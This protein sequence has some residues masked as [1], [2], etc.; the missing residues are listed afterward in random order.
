MTTRLLR[1]LLPLCFFAVLL[2]RVH[3]QTSV[4]GTQ[5]LAFAR[6][7]SAGM[8]GQINGVA[9][10]A[11]G[12]VYLLLDQKDG[13]RLLKTDN[14][15]STILAQAQL[16]AVGDIGLALAVNSAGNVFI[17]GT[18]TSSTLTGT[19]G[20]A[21]PQR[22]DT[23]TNSFVAGLDS[24]LN[25][26]FVTFTGG[27]RIAASALAV[28]ND[29]VFVTGLLY[30][31][32]LPV[33][34]NGILQAAAS[35]SSGNGFVER[36]SADGT[37]LVYAT[38][39]TGASGDTSPTAIAADPTDAAYIAGS[40]TASGYPTVAALVP[41]ILSNPSGF[42]TKLTPA[43]DGITF[44]T[45][46]PGAGITSLALDTNGTTLLASGT[47]AQGQF[48]VDTV[49]S[50]LLSI[51]TQVLLKL[52]LDGSSVQ[53][54]IALAPGT[55]SHVASTSRSVAWVDGLLT[56]PLLPGTPLAGLGTG[57]ALRIPSSNSIDQSVRLGGL[58]DANPSFASLP[59]R[60]TSV[61]IDPTG[62]PFFAGAVLPTASS[63]LL[64]TETYELPLTSATSALPSSLRTTEQTASTCT[65]SL[66]AGSAAYLTRINPAG[67]SAALA[68]SV[69]DA[70]FVTLRN[71]SSTPA[72]SLTL[73]SS[74]GQPL[75]TCTQ[76]L[77]AGADC[78]AILPGTAAST[79]TLSAG[80]AATQQFTVPASAAQSSTLVFS[81]RELDFGIVPA[82]TPA[83][84]TITVT[85]LGSVAQTFASTLDSAGTSPYSE[86]SSDCTSSGAVTRKTLP[87]GATC[88]VVLALT[89]STS[90]TD[91]QS[92]S[93]L[94]GTRDIALTGYTQLAA[95]TLSAS[96]LDFGTQFANGLRLPR[97][98]YLYN[99]TS[100]AFAHTIATLPSG[101]PFTVSDTCPTSIASAQICRI[102]V[103]Y[104]SSTVP[105]NDTAILNLDA[106]ASVL[107]TGKTLAA[108]TITGTTV[109]PNLGVTPTSI[110]FANAVVVTGVSPTT[111][112]VS[113]TNT[114]ASPFALTLALSGDFTD[115]TSCGATLAGGQTCAVA[116]TFAPSEPGTRTGVLAVT[117]GA[118]TSPAY[119][120][121]T[122]TGTAILPANDGTLS[123]GGVPVSQPRV[124]FYKVAQPFTSLAAV[125]SGPYTVALVEDIGYGYGHPSAASYSAATKGTCS[126][127]FLAIQFLPTA[128]GP[129][130]GTLTLSSAAGGS[131]Y[132]LTLTGLGLP[133]TG[134]LINPLAQDFGT[135]PV[136]SQSGANLFT[137]TNLTAAGIAVTLTVPATTGD[138]TPSTNA[139]GGQ[140]CTG[141]LAYTASC[142]VAVQFT[143]T[144]TGA[145]TGTLAV[146]S[147]GGNATATLTGFSS[148]DPGISIRPLALTFSDVPG[149]TEIRQTVTLT[150]TGTS[151]LQVLTPTIGTS[152]LRRIL[153]LRLARPPPPPAPSPSPTPPAQPT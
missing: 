54:S 25:L 122:G 137:V 83:T 21:I 44:S 15:A 102:R 153:H 42:L 143:P 20:A 86:S 130:P 138:F 81:P 53:S 52:P 67:S 115:V 35:G 56:L 136:N 50:P 119:V 16:G 94:I 64:S 116:L 1:A 133:T 17:T 149:P 139:T 100:A 134:L 140:T 24:S 60:I 68:V 41:A 120:T 58:P 28:T 37:A 121:L 36:F 18:T 31:T 91:L 71:L 129:Q 4:N 74:A 33:T 87:A 5:Q 29:S 38:Y 27:S 8:Q 104:L 46:I 48:P 19:S 84:R 106:G 141:T 85:N 73:T 79:F 107:L 93:W 92:G 66:C 103:D 77:A 125:T 96:E 23:S 10:D 114:G 148:A 32:N 72:M 123:F 132:T 2:P 146:G 30:G 51:A 61:A 97:F 142:L 110:T 150:N 145:R 47:V 111:Q 90:F 151:N 109:N 98:L 127:C 88:H 59:T 99:S 49:A 40:T 135:V 144:A 152:L 3:G 6:L 78:E 101:S 11:T 76:I 108:R 82:G 80:N 34:S 55:Q 57:F 22:T 26:R 12:N 7:R 39:L 131:P 65:G 63:S 9:T 69:D 70:P 105:S 112:N 43:G 117:A 126:N 118:G 128:A 13:V 89:A 14:T 147:T 113:I 95:L 45:F 62:A 124:Q 75:T